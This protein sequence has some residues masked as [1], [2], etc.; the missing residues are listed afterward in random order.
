[1]PKASVLIRA[2]ARL[3][4]K[5]RRRV[6]RPKSA[7]RRSGQP[8]AAM[9]FDA[10]PPPNGTPTGDDG[11]AY[12]TLLNTV[13]SLQAD[14]QQ[15][16]TTCHS[17][18]EQNAILQR[19]HDKAREEVLRQ[20]EKVAANRTELVE[21]AKAKIEA[22]RATEALVA[23]WKVQL[24]SRTRELEEVQKKLVPQDLDML[25]IQIQEELEVPHQQKIS[26]LEAEARSFQQM[27]FN[28]RRELERSK[29][30]F[31]AYTEH[32]EAARAS[33]RATHDAE[34]RGLRRRVVE[35]EAA[36]ADGPDGADL[37][38]G[39]EAKVL[40]LEVKCRE[41]MKEND[42]LRREHDGAIGDKNAA[43]QGRAEDACAAKALTGQLKTDVVGLERR[44]A[45]ATNRI[46]KLE[47]D[48]ESKQRDL[49]AAKE[50][51]R[52]ASMESEKRDR[53]RLQRV[54]DAESAAV[55][56]RREVDAARAELQRD[57][58]MYGRKLEQCE[59]ELSTAKRQA[60]EAR[61][62]CDA[63]VNTARQEC[64]EL[65]ASLEE[66]LVQQDLDKSAA[67][68]QKRD[69]EQQAIDESRKLQA[70]LKVLTGK[71]ARLE[72]DV[73]KTHKPKI[74]LLEDEKAR[75]ALDRDAHKRRADALEAAEN[76]ALKAVDDKDRAVL[77]VKK[78]ETKYAEARR[79]AE[80]FREE[81][82]H[83]RETHARELGDVRA[84]IAEDKAHVAEAI[85]AETDAIRREASAEL[86]KERK[87]S[88]AYKEKCLQ[89]HNREKRLTST[90]KATTRAQAED[91]V[92]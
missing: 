61:M 34:H 35:L 6:T 75:V 85:R 72:G 53:A 71:V 88:A 5:R 56:L 82:A 90:L 12:A 52:L 20:R 55:D 69:F 83:L 74:Q 2:H 4:A 13:E 26:D 8:A 27:F 19:D 58:D 10:V 17:L 45:E 63:T 28:V 39:L 67:E 22:D 68:K 31:A 46:T 41:L 33:D 51:Y 84:Q 23:K 80:R 79:E 65:C 14:L 59:T 40:A 25:R 64:R 43:V 60:F 30:E 47:Q 87:R 11:A 16:I 76:A 24:D 66:R 73:E 70:E 1:L 32:Q 91:L 62:Q 89:A 21:Q 77:D 48:V 36:A 15:T 92:A 54:A 78:A 29:T 81:I 7:A 42:D 18:R 86:K 3:Y 37:Q 49:D 9:M 50:N 38:R 57:A 44:L